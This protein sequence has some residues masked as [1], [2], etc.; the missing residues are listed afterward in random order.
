MLGAGCSITPYSVS[1]RCAH[2]KHHLHNDY[3]LRCV[4]SIAARR[5]HDRQTVYTDPGVNADAGIL[6]NSSA[7]Q[8]AVSHPPHPRTCVAMT[9]ARRR[10][11]TARQIWPPPSRRWC[12]CR[13]QARWRR[14]LSAPVQTSPGVQRQSGSPALSH[15]VW[16]IDVRV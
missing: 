8:L 5:T 14:G 3:I 16:H 15:A 9:T 4:C 6:P 2:N 11:R 12:Q 7:V 10:S 13:L 1:L